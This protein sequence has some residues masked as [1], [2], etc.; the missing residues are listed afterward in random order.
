MPKKLTVKLSADQLEKLRLRI[1][2][3]GLNYSRIARVWPDQE[4]ISFASIGAKLRGD[5][6]F[7]TDQFQKIVKIIE[8]AEKTKRKLEKCL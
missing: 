5:V 1:N 8:D 3:A 4:N 7:S 2:R 6:A